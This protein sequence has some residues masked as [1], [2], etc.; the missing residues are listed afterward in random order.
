MLRA[1]CEDTQPAAVC[2]AESKHC[3]RRLVLAPFVGSKSQTQAALFWLESA[4]E[5]SG[6]R[7]T[8]TIIQV[9]FYFKCYLVS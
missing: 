9:R 4:H 8:K 1:W 5:P 6:P 7:M 2:N 3:P